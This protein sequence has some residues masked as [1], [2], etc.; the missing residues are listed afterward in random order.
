M[1]RWLKTN[2]Y[3]EKNYSLE[4]IYLLKLTLFPA[5]YIASFLWSSG[6]ILN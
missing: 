4:E 6:G 2:V 1:G 3:Q 5:A